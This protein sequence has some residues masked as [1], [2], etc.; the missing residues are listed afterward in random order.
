MKKKKSN[1]ALSLAVSSASFIP[2]AIEIGNIPDEFSALKMNGRLSYKSQCGSLL[3][4]RLIVIEI[5]CFY[6]NEA[7]LLEMFGSLVFWF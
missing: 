7:L 1:K 3:L 4:F 2:Y 6:L 5:E